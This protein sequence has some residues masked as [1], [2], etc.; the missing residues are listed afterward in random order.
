MRVKNL[1]ID[2]TNLEFRVFF[3]SKQI[4]MVNN[5]GEQISCVYRFLTTYKNLVDQFNPD[6]VY[7][8]WDRK[9]DR[10]SRNFRQELL[11]DQYK[12]GRVKPPDVDEMYEQ[13]IKLIEGLEM[14]GCKHMFP[15][16][17]EADDVVAWLATKLDGPNVIVSVDNDLLQLVNE[18]NSVYNL[19]KLITLDNFLRE[20]GVNIEHFKLYKAIKGDISDNIPG[21]PGFGTV[22]ARKLAA[23]WKNINITE[24]LKNIVERNLKLID[25]NYG[26]T[27]QPEEVTSYENQFRYLTGLHGNIDKFKDYCEKNGFI[28]Y[29]KRFN[30]WKHM[31]NRNKLVDLISA[32]T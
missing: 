27:A 1:I 17:L 12:A 21:I 26:Y 13:E 24:S 25:L 32:I 28:E 4:K 31:F 20:I 9:L 5:A 22:R 3:I 11:A 30:D 19:K 16:A 23:N 8:A 15:N 29:L 7:C 6:N 10:N 14:L 2:G 18:K